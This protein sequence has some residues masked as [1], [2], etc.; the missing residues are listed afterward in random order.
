MMTTYGTYC[1]QILDDEPAPLDNRKD[2]MQKE[3]KA[4]AKMQKKQYME[5]LSASQSSVK[6]E[7]NY[8]LA[9]GSSTPAQEVPA[10]DYEQ[11]KLIDDLYNHH[12]CIDAAA[13]QELEL[14]TRAQHQSDRWHYERKLRETA[15]GIIEICHQHPTT[16][17]M[18]FVKR[19][20]SS[21]PSDK[22]CKKV[23]NC[24]DFQLC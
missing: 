23:R 14:S 21:R 5:Q 4:R 24:C 17:C 10:S 11:Q 7:H 2:E 9:K 20:F 15:S 18:A 8:A 12:V 6:Y 22:L 3:R 19:K 13:I 16:S 1:L